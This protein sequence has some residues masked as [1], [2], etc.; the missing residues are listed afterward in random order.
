MSSFYGGRRGPQG[1]LGPTGPTGPTGVR[2]NVPVISV[3]SPSDVNSSDLY[4]NKSLFNDITL[5]VGD[6]FIWH[7][8]GN[9]VYMCRVNSVTDTQYRISAPEMVNLKGNQGSTG[10]TGP[11]GPHGPAVIT[12]EVGE[13]TLYLTSVQ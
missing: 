8:D 2:G 5:S 12:S 7:Q 4:F 6:G 13:G 9:T 1:P 10:P 11:T 3:S